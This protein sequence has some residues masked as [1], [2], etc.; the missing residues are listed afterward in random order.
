MIEITLFILLII[1]CI[2][3]AQLNVYVLVITNLKREE[4]IQKVSEQK[5]YI[6][7]TDSIQDWQWEGPQE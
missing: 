3:G 7:P 1:T 2:L 6:T 4:L 5:E